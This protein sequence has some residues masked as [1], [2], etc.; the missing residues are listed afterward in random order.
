M[1]PKSLGAVIAQNRNSPMLC[2][3]LGAVTVHGMNPKH[4]P[5]DSAESKLSHAGRCVGRCEGAGYEPQI[6]AR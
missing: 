4:S 1:N 3:A 2:A 6:L 5:C